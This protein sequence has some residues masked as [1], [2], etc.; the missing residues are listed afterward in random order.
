MIKLTQLGGDVFVLNADLIKYVETRPDTIVTLTGGER[1]LV[2]ETIDEVLRR[3]V[4]YQ[5]SKHLQPNTDYHQPW[6]SRLSPASAAA[7]H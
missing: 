7:S 2:R 6:I 4:D 3:A 1:L 5:R